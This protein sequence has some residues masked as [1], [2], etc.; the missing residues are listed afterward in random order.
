MLLLELLMVKL[1]LQFLM[2]KLPLQLLVELVLRE[3]DGAQRLLAR[4]PHCAAQLR[5]QIVGL[6]CWLGGWIDLAFEVCQVSDRPY[7]RANIRR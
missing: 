6:D 1:L 3:H 4:L 2:E 5:R 7:P